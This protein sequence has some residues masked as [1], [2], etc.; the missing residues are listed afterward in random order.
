VPGLPTPGTYLLTFSLNGYGSRTIVVDL[1][2]GQ[3]RSGVDVAVVG[4]TGTVTGRVLDSAGNGLGG[5]TVSVG[6]GGSSATTTTLTSGT[7]GLFVLSALPAPGSYTLTVSLPGYAP[8]S[9]PVALAAAGAPPNVEVRMPV[10]AGSIAG[11]VHGCA[12]PAGQP[13][14]PAECTPLVGAKVTATDGQQVW[15]TTSTIAG[16]TAADG[17]TPLGPGGYNLTSL[18]A[19]TYAVTVTN[20]GKVQRTV[21]VTVTAGTASTAQT[22]ELPQAVS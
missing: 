13:N 2:A 22:V 18:P 8:Q 20:A 11:V 17:T 7:V 3:S 1:G 14:A 21:L 9:V 6:G 16:A 12:P 19:G 4:G 10:S 5:A 15:T